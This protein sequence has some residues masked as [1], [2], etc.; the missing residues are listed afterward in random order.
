MQTARSPCG[1]AAAGGPRAGGSALLPRGEAG[2]RQPRPRGKTP[3]PPV[4]GRHAPLGSG[5]PSRGPR[6]ASQVAGGADL[7][8]QRPAPPRPP[9]PSPA[10]AH[11][12]APRLPR[13]ARE[14]L[15]RARSGA[16]P[17]PHPPPGP[18]ARTAGPRGR[19]LHQ[20]HAGVLLG[21]RQVKLPT[22]RHGLSPEEACD[23]ER[24]LRETTGRRRR[25]PAR[26]LGTQGKRTTPPA[27]R[28]CACAHHGP[29]GALLQTN[30]LLPPR[31]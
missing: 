12:R 29:D 23:P 14:G 4:W 17:P 3:G 18:A 25:P 2:A 24:R 27:A 31:V 7:A 8:G 21:A 19:Y 30:F 13:D 20:P 5:T 28:D 15:E 9:R 26:K 16:P 10:D 6:K 1:R 11:P 22:L